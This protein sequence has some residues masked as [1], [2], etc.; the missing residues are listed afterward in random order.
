MNDFRDNLR[1]SYYKAGYLLRTKRISKKVYDEMINDI[2]G[3]VSNVNE[4]N[5]KS[6]R[7]STLRKNIHIKKLNYYITFTIKKEKQVITDE[8]IKRSITQML[9]RYE[10]Q[11]IIVAEFTKNEVIHFH[12]FIGNVKNELI[13]QKIIN[14]KEVIDKF[15]NQVLEFIPLENNY[16]FTQVIDISAK[17]EWETEKMLKYIMKY[18]SKGNEKFMSSRLTNDSI[19]LAKYY[20][21]KEIV[22]KV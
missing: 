18:V 16:G 6:R 17:E 8:N 13:Q 14:D 5:K 15:G 11:Y 4:R 7:L 10:I 12:G 2:N 22:K 3:W 9:R 20:F 1:Q 21:G 19:D